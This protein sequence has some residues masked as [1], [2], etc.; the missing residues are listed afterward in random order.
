MAN[1]P[2][3]TFTHK[4][5]FNRLES[6]LVNS[7]KLKVAMRPI[8]EK[9]GKRGVELLREATPKDT[10]KTAESWAYDIVEDKNGNLKI[11]WSNTNVQDGVL[12]AILLQYGHAT[13]NGGYVEGTNYIN[14][15]IERT[16]RRLA[17]EAWEEVAQ[18][19]KRGR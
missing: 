15:A 5:N 17:D 11:V 13:K 14:P 19:G 10:G 18:N 7:L 6:F 12:V 3:I 1:K 8:L 4:G 2:F 16:F 9:Y